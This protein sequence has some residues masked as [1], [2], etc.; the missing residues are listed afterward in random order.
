MQF[1]WDEAKSQ[2]V[3]AERGCSFEELVE[4]ITSFGLLDILENPRY[5]NQYQYIVKLK[6]EIWVVIVEERKRKDK[7]FFRIVTAWPDRKMRKIYGN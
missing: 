3:Q 6:T 4:E 1:E 5:P 7:D 2:R